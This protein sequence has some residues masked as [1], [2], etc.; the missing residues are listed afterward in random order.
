MKK[1]VWL[2]VLTALAITASCLFAA[3]CKSSGGTPETPRFKEDAPTE[4]FLSRDID[5]DDYIVRVDGEDAEVSVEYY[6]PVS[7]R[8]SEEHTSELHDGRTQNNVYGKKRRNVQKRIDDRNG[9]RR[10]ADDNRIAYGS[11]YPY[12]RFGRS[13]EGVRLAYVE[14]VHEPQARYGDNKSRRRIF[15]GGKRRTRCG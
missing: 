10:S 12:A 15:Q 5:L 13:Y 2:T 11:D 8:R 4:V 1:N 7:D 6:N 3:S 14:R 9:H